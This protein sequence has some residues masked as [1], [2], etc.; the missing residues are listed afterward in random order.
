MCV[1]G[2]PD[3]AF[4][5][6]AREMAI[7]FFFFFFKTSHQYIGLKSKGGNQFDILKKPAKCVFLENLTQHF[8]KKPAK[9]VF[10]FFFLNLTQHFLKKPAKWQFFFFFFFKKDREPV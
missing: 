4:C 7:F 8:V 2:K 1:F 10:F 5:E 9:C 3:S 6:K